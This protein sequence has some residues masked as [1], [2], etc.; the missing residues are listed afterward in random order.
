M[1]KVFVGP[2]LCAM[3]FARCRLQVKEQDNK[4]QSRYG[5]V[6]RQNS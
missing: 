5:Q 1:K 6:E 3:L 4:Y 2:T